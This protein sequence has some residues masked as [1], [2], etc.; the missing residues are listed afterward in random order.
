MDEQDKGRCKLAY[1]QSLPLKVWIIKNFHAPYLKKDNR[2][3]LSKIS[4]VD[5]T[6]IQQWFANM[7]RRFWKPIMN[8]DQPEG[9]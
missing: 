2:H 8:S 6:R 1:E 3:H 7:R 9:R 4:G 5:E